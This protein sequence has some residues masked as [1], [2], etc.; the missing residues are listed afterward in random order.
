MTLRRATG[1]ENDVIWVATQTD[2]I[3]LVVGVLAL[4][5]IAT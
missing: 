1:K 2:I 5:V 4:S 3:L